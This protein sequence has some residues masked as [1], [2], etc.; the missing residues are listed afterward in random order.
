ML[1]SYRFKVEENTFQALFD[2]FI[3]VKAAEGR[4]EHTLAS[5]QA[6]MN[7]IGFFLDTG[8]NIDEYTTAEIRKAVG[9]M[10]RSDLSRNTIRSY[11][12]TLSTFFSW[13]RAEG[14]SDVKIALF[15]GEESVPTT[16]SPSELTRLL[17]RPKRGAEFSEFR[18]WV[19]I[20]LLVNNGIRA[21]SVRAIEV[22]DV[23]L[24]ASV[25]YLRHT[26]N[27][28]TQ[29]IPLSPELS[30]IIAEYLKIRRGE[31]EDPLFPDM[32]GKPMSAT[33]LRGA[34]RRYN[35]RRGVNKGGIHAFRHTFARMYLVDCNGNALKLQRL[36]GHS[37][38]DMT[39]KYVQIF[40]KDLVD[41]FQQMSP[42]EAIKKTSS[43]RNARKT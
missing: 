2:E 43:Q 32:N 22:R 14:L 7:A 35:E 25:I 9:K 3:T 38:L 36:L 21:A 12:A 37:T 15:C 6:H 20:N 19:I 29:A 39:K 26:K 16:Y 4:S 33:C 31:P 28:R 5:Y 17:K 24:D 1:R 41:D 40:D 13:L 8:K 23:S 30:K 18:T 27:R 42:L 10:A 34:I 11:T